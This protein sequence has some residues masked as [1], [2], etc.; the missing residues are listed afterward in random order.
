MTKIASKRNDEGIDNRKKIT[1]F[2]CPFFD[3]SYEIWTDNRKYLND[4]QRVTRDWNVR[5]KSIKMLIDE[6]DEAYNGCADKCAD[7]E[8]ENIVTIRVTV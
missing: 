2:I 8:I 1:Y 5:D 7:A 6:R 3:K 4:N